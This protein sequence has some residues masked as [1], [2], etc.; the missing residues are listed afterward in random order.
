MSQRVLTNVTIVKQ[1][2]ESLTIE[3]G[4]FPL[5][6]IYF[7]C[8]KK[9]TTQNVLGALAVTEWFSAMPEGMLH[10]KRNTIG[11]D[12]QQRKLRKRTV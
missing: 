5:K 4:E 6:M 8:T 9:K 11:R 3:I 10:E 7:K 1:K 12:G 2:S